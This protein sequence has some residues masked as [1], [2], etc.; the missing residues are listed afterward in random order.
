MIKH[1]YLI[2]IEKYRNFCFYPTSYTFS[3]EKRVTLP[4]LHVPL[5]KHKCFR[6]S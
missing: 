5:A 6:I 3:R 4:V 1:V 2:V